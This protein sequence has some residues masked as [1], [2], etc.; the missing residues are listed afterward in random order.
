M[1]VV[2]KVNLSG[3]HALEKSLKK[4]QSVRG[5]GLIGVKATELNFEQ[6]D[7]Q[8]DRDGKRFPPY[9]AR[10]QA[11]RKRLGLTPTGRV[12]LTI[13]HEMLD[14]FDV[15][16]TTRKSVLIGFSSVAEKRKAFG[17]MRNKKR[18]I[19]FVGLTKNSEKKLMRF[20]QK[21]WIDPYSKRKK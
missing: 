20:I 2:I 3:L 12:D 11:Q 9:S 10:W 15:Q 8:K 7:A 13:T 1:S 14:N 6:I 19:N 17:V 16:K 4:I 5:Q 21:R 18:P